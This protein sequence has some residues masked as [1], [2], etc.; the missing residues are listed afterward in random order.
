MLGYFRIERINGKI[1]EFV[2][3]IDISGWKN[4]LELFFIYS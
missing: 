4:C 3:D 2:V 1:I